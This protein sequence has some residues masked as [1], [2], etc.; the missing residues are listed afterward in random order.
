MNKFQ[1]RYIGNLRTESVHLDSNTQIETDAPKDNLGLGEKFS[2]T[3]LVCSSLGSCMVTIMALF[4]RKDGI[5]LSGL[6]A[7]VE[8]VMQVTPRKIKEIKLTI[9]CEMIKSMTLEYKDK[10]KKVALGCPVALSLN[11][12]IMQNVE[13]DF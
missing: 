5:E 1:V 7:D 12:D 10:L 3:D 13:F 8:K 2:P 9:K 4:A 11:P 6:G